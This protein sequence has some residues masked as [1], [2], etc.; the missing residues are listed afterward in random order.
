MSNTEINRPVAKSGLHGPVIGGFLAA[1]AFYTLVHSDRIDSLLIERYFAGHPVEYIMT[2]MFFVGMAVLVRKLLD[3]AREPRAGKSCLLGQASE[4]KQTVDDCP[5]LLQRF[6]ELP[7]AVRSSLLGRRIYKAL[8]YVHRTSSS[9]GLEDQLRQLAESDEAESYSSYSLVR[10]IISTIPI[11]GFLGTVIGITR[12]VAELA[13]IVGEMSF[14]QAINSVVS[15]L[16][17]AFDT[18]ALALALSIVLMFAMFFVSRWELRRLA[19]VETAADAEL[20]GR[21]RVD[22]SDD[23]VNVLLIRRMAK[24]VVESTEKLVQKQAELW[25]RSLDSASKRWN[26]M[27]VTTEHQLETALSRVLQA[28][29]DAHAN[30]LK[31]AEE[32]AEGR[33]GRYWQ[34]ML[35]T[36]DSQIEVIREQYGELKRQ[37]DIMTRAIDATERIGQLEDSLNQNL[38]ALHHSNKFDEAVNTL[39]AAISV[40]NAKLGQVPGGGPQVSLTN[41][42][43]TGYAA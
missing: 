2:V 43:N 26:N 34:E 12:A 6:S 22:R 30:Q 10:I 3:V 1:L 35:G 16:S 19:E 13:Q 33:V 27:A 40:L 36:M 20:V 17:V 31:E 25:E 28:S 23:D 37:G 4:E 24:E 39:A 15:G 11:L 29:A 14:E 7:S 42:E 32:A 9:A 41:T 21:F 5:Y 38:A 18:T 8:C